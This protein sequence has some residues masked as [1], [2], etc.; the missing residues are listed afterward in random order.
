MR[1]ESCGASITYTRWCYSIVI[2]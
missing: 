1:L 2:E